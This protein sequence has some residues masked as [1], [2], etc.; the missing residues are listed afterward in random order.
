MSDRISGEIP[1][2]LRSENGVFTTGLI[3]KH[4]EAAEEAGLT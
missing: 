4:P 2:E 3:E 1:E